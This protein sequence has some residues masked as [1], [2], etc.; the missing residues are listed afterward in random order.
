[1]LFFVIGKDYIPAVNFLL[2]TLHWNIYSSITGPW[3]SNSICWFLKK[4]K[5]GNWLVRFDWG[6]FISFH[7]KM[8]KYRVIILL[9][10][11]LL[12]LF[13]NKNIQYE[14]CNCSL[15]LHSWSYKTCNSHSL[16]LFIRYYVFTLLI[17]VS[18][19]RNALRLCSL[20]TW[21]LF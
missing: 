16:G 8:Q 3:W 12:W 5:Y 9:W 4:L 6:W 17:L 14:L 21:G 20:W 10:L 18:L 2:P 1:M 19:S 13:P 11:L 7:Y 15:V